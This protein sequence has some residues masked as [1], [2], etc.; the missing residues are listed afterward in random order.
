MLRMLA[1]GVLPYSRVLRI[2]SADFIALRNTAQCLLRPDLAI[3][4]H[5]SKYFNAFHQVQPRHL[6]ST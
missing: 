5:W 1:A 3:L 6:P 4:T 2:E